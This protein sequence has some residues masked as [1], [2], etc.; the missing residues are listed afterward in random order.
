MKRKRRLF[1]KKTLTGSQQPIQI[2]LTTQCSE[3]ETSAVEVLAQSAKLLEAAP[4]R[5]SATTTG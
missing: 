4:E 1:E 2:G 5:P 3:I